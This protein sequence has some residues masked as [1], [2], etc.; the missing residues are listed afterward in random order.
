MQNAVPQPP[1][2]PPAMAA[3]MPVTQPRTSSRGSGGS[4]E[5]RSSKGSSESGGQGKPVDTTNAL[6]Q[7]MRNARRRKSSCVNNLS[8]N[9]VASRPICVIVVVLIVIVAIVGLGLHH[10]PPKIETDLDSF[11]KA[12]INVSVYYDAFLSAKEARVSGS[13]PESTYRVYDLVMAYELSDTERFSSIFDFEVLLSIASFEQQLV[14]LEK[15]KE[16]C[17]TPEE[18]HKGLCTPGISI[19]NYMMPTQQSARGVVVPERLTLDGRGRDTIPLAAALRLLELHG[20]LRGI[21]PRGF[22]ED[23]P[24]AVTNVRSVFRF[25]LPVSDGARASELD[26]KWK[27]LLREALPWLQ[28]KT[29]K[30][31]F[32]VKIYLTGDLVEEVQVLDTLKSDLFSAI[33]SI[34]LVCAYMVCHTRSFFLAFTGLVIYVLA[35]LMA[36]V[37]FAACVTESLSISC[38]LLVFFM[39]GLTSDVFFVYVDTWRESQ[40]AGATPGSRVAWTYSRAGQVTF[41][42]TSTLV[43]CFFV[44]LSSNLRPLRELGMLLALGMIF[45]W[46]L[47]SFLCLPCCMLYDQHF[48]GCRLF[49]CLGE[50]KRGELAERWSGTLHKLQWPFVGFA[51]ISFLIFLVSAFA[52]VKTDMRVPKVFPE[53]HNQHRGQDVVGDNFEVLLDVLDHDFGVPPEAVEVCPET[54]FD[55][56]STSL[57]TIFWCDVDVIVPSLESGR[58][59]RCKRKDDDE[60]CG[61]TMQ[62]PTAKV[63]ERF[64]GLARQSSGQILGPI[65]DRIEAEAAGRGLTFVGDRAGNM[66]SRNLKPVLLHEWESGAASLQPFMQ[67]QARL[68]RKDDYASCGW[69]DLCFCSGHICKLDNVVWRPSPSIDLVG[70]RRLRLGASDAARAAEAAGSGAAGSAP[71]VRWLQGTPPGVTW[72]VPVSMRA[73]VVV[74]FGIQVED[75]TPVVGQSNASETWSFQKSFQAKH[76]RAQRDM[77]ALCTQ[78]PANLL[79]TDWS[80]WVERFHYWLLSR[81]DRF[82]VPMQSFDALA[83]KFAESYPSTGAPYLWMR[84]GEVQASYIEFTVDVSKAEEPKRVRSYKQEWDRYLEDWNADASPFSRG[85]WHASALW[86]RGEA[87]RDL[88]QNMAVTMGIL[89]PCAFVVILLSTSNFLLSFYVYLAHEW[90]MSS[91][92]FFMTVLLRWE[93]GPIEMIGILGFSG[94]AFTYALHLVQFYTNEEAETESM[95]SGLSEK[96]APRYRQTSYALKAIGGAITGSAVTTALSAFLLLFCTLRVFSKLGAT[97]LITSALSF[98]CSL[99]LLPAAL[100][101]GGPKSRKQLC[102]ACCSHWTLWQP[103][104]RLLLRIRGQRTGG[105]DADEMPLSPQETDSPGLSPGLSVGS[106]SRSSGSARSTGSRPGS[107]ERPVD[108]R[109]SSRESAAI[110]ISA[111]ASGL[112]K[113]SS[114]GQGKANKVSV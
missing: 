114:P 58:E 13:T 6:I 4:K 94:Y 82:P 20:L 41:S 5:R 47:A 84:D 19:V 42:S 18:R 99:A 23:A 66:S 37:V 68:Q 91:V 92:F 100:L 46:I 109:Q 22:D 108:S 65:G 101:I 67:V 15:F 7:A 61:N 75:K 86:Q 97:L 26:D 80:C 107:K 57:C 56:V 14:S 27:D 71:P 60:S 103:C 111:L 9:V 38:F 11:M 44:L 8:H 36:Y 34:I 89:R 83:L 106:G 40:K 112:G 88:V 85:A 28:E 59:C 95:R 77:Y 76:P 105:S 32:P 29:E 21:L 62:S 39:L 70:T 24:T 50:S 51:V 102:C 73:S 55:T 74:V 25:K 16:L 17:D 35:I 81:G 48:A 113:T 43:V 110:S 90:I 2:P 93:F 52:S 63:V 33:G 87:E 72:N 30:G 78:V 10:L 12:N 53:G 31:A 98:L 45:A 54:A 104:Q 69:Q 79:V 3:E 1:L 49:R 96:E 64:V